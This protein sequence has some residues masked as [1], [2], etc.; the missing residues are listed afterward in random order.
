MRFLL[1]TAYTKVS[2]QSLMITNCQKIERNSV[3]RPKV[4]EVD[5][6]LEGNC[7]RKEMLSLVVETDVYYIVFA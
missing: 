6:G 7:L 3:Q 5:I 1:Y 2:Q 4:G